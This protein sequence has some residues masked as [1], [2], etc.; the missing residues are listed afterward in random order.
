MR[1]VPREHAARQNGGGLSEDIDIFF[2]PTFNTHQKD[3]RHII[4][5]SLTAFSS[6]GVIEKMR[7]PLANR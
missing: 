5:V 1:S 4:G 6:G 7:G 2:D 3:A